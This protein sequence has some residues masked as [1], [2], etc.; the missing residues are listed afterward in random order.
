M[1]FL[2]IRPILSGWVTCLY[3][4]CLYILC[5]CIAVGHYDCLWANITLLSWKLIA[6]YSYMMHINKCILQL[7]VSVNIFGL[8]Y[9]YYRNLRHHIVTQYKCVYI[10][11][12]FY[13]MTKIIVSTFYVWDH[14]DRFLL[15]QSTSWNFI[16]IKIFTNN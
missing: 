12:L 16:G 11:N 6:S 8:S 3:N 5:I 14:N 4:I 15:G 2:A 9:M 13:C 7:S 10:N 1:Y